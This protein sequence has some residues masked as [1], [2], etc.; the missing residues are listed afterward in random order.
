MSMPKSHQY[1]H[2]NLTFLVGAHTCTSVALALQIFNPHMSHTF[3]Y[4]LLLHPIRVV[5]FPISCYSM[6]TYAHV[7]VHIV[8]LCESYVCILNNANSDGG[9]GPHHRSDPY[10][11][12]LVV[13]ACSP[14]TTTSLSL[15]PVSPSPT[16]HHQPPTTTAVL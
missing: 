6:C 1:M 9:R 16:L 15:H 8:W 5:V 10:H 11:A 4:N 3:C 2:C 14:P 12:T 13:Y 7:C